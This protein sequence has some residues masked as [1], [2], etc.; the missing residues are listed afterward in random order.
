MS[1]SIYFIACVRISFLWQNSI[2]LCACTFKKSIH[3]PV[4]TWVVFVGFFGGRGE[5]LFVLLECE[6]SKIEFDKTVQ[7]WF[8]CV[9]PLLE[10]SVC[11]HKDDYKRSHF[12]QLA[13]IMATEKMTQN[14]DPTSG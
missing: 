3:L 9:D 7:P 8:S 2:P 14:V 11:C 5:V 1:F 4:D 10:D 6:Y 12:V 13:H